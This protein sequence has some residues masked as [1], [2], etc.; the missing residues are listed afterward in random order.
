MVT[1]K[2]EEKPWW[3]HWHGDEE[4][5]SP[6]FPAKIKGRRTLYSYGTGPHG[7]EQFL[8]QELGE[9]EFEEPF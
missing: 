6:E 1:V 2:D 7:E 4:K 3:W 8:K 9:V 5:D